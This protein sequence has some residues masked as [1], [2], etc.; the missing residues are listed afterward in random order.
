MDPT[1]V[2]TT[3]PA[4]DEHD[5]IAKAIYVLALPAADDIQWPVTTGTGNLLRALYKKHFFQ[6]FQLAHILLK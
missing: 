6:G 5:L 3:E 4:N 2:F 1:A